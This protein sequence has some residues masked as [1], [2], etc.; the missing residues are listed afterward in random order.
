M[1]FGAERLEAELK[2]AGF[3]GVLSDKMQEPFIY[4]PANDD[5]PGLEIN[6]QRQKIEVRDPMADALTVLGNNIG[7]LAMAINRLAATQEKP[8]SKGAVS[9][10]TA[11]FEDQPDAQTEELRDLSRQ[12]GEGGEE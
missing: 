11:H 9:F 3:G 8:K 12:R 2:R 7:A 4:A 6:M 5:I 1:T 10:T